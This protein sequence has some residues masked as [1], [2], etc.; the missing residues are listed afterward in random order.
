MSRT[1]STYARVTCHYHFYDLEISADWLI[2]PEKNGT[3]RP[4]Y[5]VRNT[6]PNELG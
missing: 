1:R 6:R 2:L 4:S 5:R 3:I